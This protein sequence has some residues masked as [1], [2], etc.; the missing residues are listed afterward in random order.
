MGEKNY[1]IFIENKD[2]NGSLVFIFY[3]KFKA[4]NLFYD[5]HDTHNSGHWGCSPGWEPPLVLV[6]QPG[7]QCW[8]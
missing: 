3:L 7:L 1:Q 6:A 5:E 2:N 4:Y 8:N